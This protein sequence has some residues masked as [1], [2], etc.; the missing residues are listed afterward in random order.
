VSLV[1]G[2]LGQL[3]AAPEVRIT[4]HVSTIL[5]LT[6]TAGGVLANVLRAGRVTPHRIQGAVAAYL[7]LALIFAFA[8]S[9]TE[10]LAPGSFH[11]PA[12]IVAAPAGAERMGEL[13][14]F[15]FVTL[16]TLGYGDVTP[17]SPSARTLATLEALV[18]QLYLAILIA[19]LVSLQIAH[20]EER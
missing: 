3:V 4:F 19:R 16:T 15:S 6:L 18:G 9:L 13:V 20:S 5:F 1:S 14:Y 7:L 10:I 2:W 12:P 8:Y 11:L 17:A